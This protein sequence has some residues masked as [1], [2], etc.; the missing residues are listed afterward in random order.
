M[1][2]PNQMQSHAGVITKGG[3]FCLKS[4]SIRLQGFNQF[5]TVPPWTFYR[6]KNKTTLWTWDQLNDAQNTLQCKSDTQLKM[7]NNGNQL[8][9]VT[10]HR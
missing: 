4:Y 9:L 6:D 7:L 2:N 10:M 5:K 8:E 3:L 1:W